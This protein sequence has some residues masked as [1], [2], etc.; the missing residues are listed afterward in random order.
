MEIL[1]ALTR[2]RCAR[3]PS[4]ASAGEGKKKTGRGLLRGRLDLNQFSPA[5]QPPD[6]PQLL[7]ISTSLVSG[8]KKMPITTVIAAKI[9][10]YQRPA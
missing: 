4:P 10:G 3:P 8:R 6:K 1:T 2:P 7:L 9:T 5:A